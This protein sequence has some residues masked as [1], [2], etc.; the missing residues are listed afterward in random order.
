MTG[1][2]MKK[3]TYKTTVKSILPY[4]TETWTLKDK[5]KNNL[6]ATEMN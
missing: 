1:L 4:E 6:L 2:Q 5:H 3:L